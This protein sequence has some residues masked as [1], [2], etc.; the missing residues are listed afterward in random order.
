MPAISLDSLNNM[1][2]K[3]PEVTV[4]LELERSKDK[5]SGATIEITV[6]SSLIPFSLSLPT[7]VYEM[8]VDDIE[9]LALQ[10]LSSDLREAANRI[11]LYVS[12]GKLPG[13]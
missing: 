10:R 5:Y 6:G 7:D 2:E 4:R 8:R 11:D 9:K 1:R 3:K 12:A 13:S